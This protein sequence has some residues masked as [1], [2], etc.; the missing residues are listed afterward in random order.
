M[1]PKRFRRAG[2]SPGRS[3]DERRQ[4][5]QVGTGPLRPRVL[6]RDSVLPLIQVESDLRATFR[7]AGV[8]PERTTTAD[9]ALGFLRPVWSQQ[10][11]QV[12]TIRG[13]LAAAYRYLWLG[14]EEGTVEGPAA[15]GAFVRV[16]RTWMP[17]ARHLGLT[18][19]SAGLSLRRG[20]PVPV[21]WAALEGVPEVSGGSVPVVAY[22]E[23][24]RLLVAGTPGEIAAEVAASLVR[25]YQLTQRGELV[26][27]LTL[28]LVGG[29]PAG[30]SHL[31][32]LPDELGVEWSPVGGAPIADGEEGSSAVSTGPG[33][34]AI[35]KG[36]GSPDGG[37]T[38]ADDH[39]DPI[40]GSGRQKGDPP[41]PGGNGT[42]R[43][44]D[45]ADDSSSD[46]NSSG[47]NWI[48]IA[49]KVGGGPSAGSGDGRRGSFSSLGDSDARDVVVQYER[50]HGREATIKDEGQPGFD[51]SSVDPGGATRFIEIKGMQKSFDGDASVLLSRRQ[52][53]DAFIR[54]EESEWWLYVVD[55]LGGR[56]PRVFPIPWPTVLAKV[57]FEAA[58]WR[59]A[60]RGAAYRVQGEWTP[61]AVGVRE[62]E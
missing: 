26:P 29:V 2:V 31:R 49:K 59:E 6:A 30:N 36:D 16:G 50:F 25:R 12:D 34:G 24:K 43:G 61:M 40:N 56:N 9:H 38:G 62:R 1:E 15:N 20:N 32:R 19:L 52:I 55:R 33:A 42:H 48:A 5:A 28:A 60:A 13:A 14:V 11:G 44:R 21:G 57:G 23:G 39:Q 46:V 7:A 54:A 45:S 51:V 18:L 8:E 22:D 4:P 10:P 37:A 17:T 58:E 47:P 41:G 35:G 3:A 27:H 53:Q